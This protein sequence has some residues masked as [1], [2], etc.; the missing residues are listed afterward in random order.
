ML[1]LFLSICYCYNL[2]TPVI[3]MKIPIC[4]FD[5]KT[6]TLC[7]KC[8]EKFRKGEIGRLDIDLS[9]DLIEIEE[10]YVPSLK[11]LVFHK[12]VN[13]DNKL[14]FL[15]VKGSRNIRK[16]EWKI[17]FRK[18]MKLGYPKIKIIEVENMH[19]V[20][21]I[22]SQVISPARILSISISWYPDES[23]EYR[24]RVYKKDLKLLSYSPTIIE[25]AI[26]KI[27][28]KRIKIIFE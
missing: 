16:K 8:L 6:R 5:A 4:Y 10:K 3:K 23:Y 14:I 21:K 24:V 1:M 27:T 11:N 9:H 2:F 15:L 17:I 26:Y 28:N 13:I 19:D 18:L 7:P 25:E 22:I 20:K 12:A